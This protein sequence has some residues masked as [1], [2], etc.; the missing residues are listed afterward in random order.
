MHKEMCSKI[1]LWKRTMLWSIHKI[2]I[3]DRINRYRTFFGFMGLLFFLTGCSDKPSLKQLHYVYYRNEYKEPGQT[4]IFIASYL[5]IDSVGNCK[6]MERDFDEGDYYRAPSRT[7]YYQ[8]QLSEKAQ[9]QLNRYLKNDTDGVQ[10]LCPKEGA[11]IRCGVG[12]PMIAY[13]DYDKTDGFAKTIQFERALAPIGLDA[14]ENFLYTLIRNA[15]R[16]EIKAFNDTA[17]ISKIEAAYR[18]I[19]YIYATPPLIKDVQHFRAAN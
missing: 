3:M 12:G 19:Q 8:L 16:Q 11:G 2:K 18:S 17:T 4:G 15:K 6:I 14:F 10:Y 5:S 1:S 7:H 9:S 13:I